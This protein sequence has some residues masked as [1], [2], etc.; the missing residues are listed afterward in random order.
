MSKAI[1][2]ANERVRRIKSTEKFIVMQ[3]MFERGFALLQGSF[4]CQQLLWSRL[5]IPSSFFRNRSWSWTE[6]E[7]S[8]SAQLSMAEQG[9][10]GMSL[11]GEQSA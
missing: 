1:R 3:K 6:L 5:Q 4:S 8:G 9:Q 7:V 2:F 11:L 10:Q